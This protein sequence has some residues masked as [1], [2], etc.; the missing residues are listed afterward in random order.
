[1]SEDKKKNNFI[2]R[3]ALRDKL[4]NT[5]AINNM[6]RE[7]I[8]LQEIQETLQ[9]FDRK[10]EE[11]EKKKINKHNTLEAK[12]EFKKKIG[13]LIYKVRMARIK[14]EERTRPDL[15]SV[16]QKQRFKDLHYQNID[17][18]INEGKLRD[19]NNLIVREL[20]I[21]KNKIHDTQRAFAESQLEY[22]PQSSV[23]SSISSIRS[24]PSKDVLSKSPSSYSIRSMS[25]TAPSFQSASNS[26][27]NDSLTFDKLKSFLQREIEAPDF[28]KHA[29]LQFKNDYLHSNNQ[30]KNNP[31]QL[32]DTFK[33]PHKNHKLASKKQ[34]RE[35][36]EQEE[37]EQEESE[38][39]SLSD[40]Q[41]SSQ[42]GLFHGKQ[43]RHFDT[44]IRGKQPRMM[45]SKRP[46][47]DEPSSSDEEYA[48][49]GEEEENSNIL[50]ID[51]SKFDTELKSLL[52]P[53]Q[54]PFKHHCGG[55]KCNCRAEQMTNS[56]SRSPAPPGSCKISPAKS[57][58]MSP[59]RSPQRS[60]PSSLAKSPPRS[61]QRSPPRSVAKS[62]PRSVAK[63]P[64]RLLD[65]SSYIHETNNIPKLKEPWKRNKPICENIY[66]P[67]N[68]QHRLTVLYHS[69][70]TRVYFMFSLHP[71]SNATTV[72]APESIHLKIYEIRTS[73]TGVIELKN[74]LFNSTLRSV[75][76]RDFQISFNQQTFQIN[77]ECLRK[78]QE[79]IVK[80]NA[81]LANQITLT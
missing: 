51:N 54:S 43:P 58:T 31:K 15:S 39:E 13:H 52:A 77:F 74:L 48:K 76:F 33:Q 38:Q 72:L 12:D 71:E 50:G 60:A 62:P 3:Q 69:G 21:L 8:Y 36:S 55:A 17:K 70:F 45:H 32:F 64:P 6:I 49:L 34:Q 24:S 46:R 68:Y 10:I 16:R 9:N 59:L 78:I 41:L 19:A 26:Y 14:Y 27:T 61:P 18:L 40:E 73:K 11:L 81:K 22:T 4:K 66:I 29:S 28:I 23:M 53:P 20:E 75:Q 44:H 5:N 7:T 30:Y 42:Q 2:E 1:M 67:Y 80:H 63:S 65:Q 35:E 47:I 57:F 25:S 37:S 79:Y 56:K